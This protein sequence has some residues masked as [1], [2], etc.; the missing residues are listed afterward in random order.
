MDHFLYRGGLLHAE[1]VPLAEIAAA[2][3]TPGLRLF[4][5][6]ARPGTT[7]CSRRRSPASTT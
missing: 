2:V 5:G 7:G 4:L 3:G 6:D 1:D